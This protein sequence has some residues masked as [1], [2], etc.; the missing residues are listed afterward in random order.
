MSLSISSLVT[1]LGVMPGATTIETKVV[2][3]SSL[4]FP[5][6]N[7]TILTQLVGQAGG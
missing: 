5:I 6:S 3:H 2:I 1:I 7:F 4:S